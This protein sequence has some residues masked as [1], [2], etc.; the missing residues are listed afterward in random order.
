MKSTATS[1]SA[2][3]YFTLS[4]EAQAR[5]KTFAQ[6]YDLETNVSI[7][8]LLRDN[9]SRQ[10]DRSGLPVFL[11]DEHNQTGETFGEKLVNAFRAVFDEGYDHVIAVGND[12]PQLTS[13][14]LSE[15]SKLLNSNSASIILGP[16]GDGGTWL[17]GFSRNAFR[18]EALKSLP[19]NSS[20]LFKTAIR[21]FETDH[22][23]VIQ[24]LESFEDVDHTKDL[25]NFLNLQPADVQIQKLHQKIT[26]LLEM[27]KHS[28]SRQ[29]LLPADVTFS[30]SFLLRGPPRIS[31]YLRFTS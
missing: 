20:D 17:M 7:A 24:I 28:V 22:E 3:L 15:A 2:V 4:P 11:F 21:H 27:V 13:G 25:Q 12:T 8:K 5:K 19:W 14:H 29:L 10:I 26:R 18:A 31:G 23:Q 6:G 1:N 16:A 30:Y 9:T